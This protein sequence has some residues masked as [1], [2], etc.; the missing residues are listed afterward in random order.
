MSKNTRGG[1]R[2]MI[3]QGT[4]GWG[5]H[6]LRKAW[7]PALALLACT[8]AQAQDPVAAFYSGRTISIS[9]A[10]PP[11]GSYD[12]YSRLAAAH[13]SKY[14]SGRP[15]FIVQNKPG[16]IGV[17]RSFYEAAPRD[18]SMIGIF[19]ETIAIV[20]LTQPEIGKWKVQELNYIGSF[21]NVNAVMMVRKGAPASTIEQL[22]T[23]SIN[24]GCN[25]PIGVS[26][27]NPAIMKKYGG[28][29]LKII[30]GYTR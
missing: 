22:K 26:Y 16:G 13:M 25:T 6:L 15:N 28:L 7:P 9:I 1:V 4:K 20:Q 19:P 12:I 11:G 21:A 24:V 14:I 23:T 17:L 8:S 3:R 18:G 2:Q 5:S 27:I 10:Y 29:A 30:C